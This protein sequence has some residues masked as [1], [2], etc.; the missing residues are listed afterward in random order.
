MYDQYAGCFAGL[1]DATFVCPD[2][3]YWD[4][5]RNHCSPIPLPPP[6]VPP[7]V[8]PAVSGWYVGEGG[9][10]QPD[11]YGVEAQRKGCVPGQYWDG[12]YQKCLPIGGH[13]IAPVR[14][15]QGGDPL[16]PICPDNT[17]WSDASQRC[18]PLGASLTGPSCSPGM[19]WDD[20]LKKCLPRS[21]GLA[22]MPSTLAD[23]HMQHATGYWT[24][25]GDMDIYAVGAAATTD[26]VVHADNA[27]AQA[28]SA[29]AA[30]S[31]PAATGTPAGQAAQ[32]ATAHAN[33]ALVHAQTA[34]QKAP[35]QPHEAI[36]HSAEAKKHAHAAAHHAREAHASLHR[37][38]AERFGHERFGRERFGR[39]RE[40]GRRGFERGRFGREWWRR[41]EFV[42]YERRYGRGW[43][44]RPE[45]AEYARLYGGVEEVVVPEY[46]APRVVEEY[47]LPADGDYDD[48]VD[49]GD[50]DAG[51]DD[52]DVD[53]G[54]DAAVQG[55]YTGW[56]DPFTT[57]YPGY[58]NPNMAA[59]WDSSFE[60]PFLTPY[61]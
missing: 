27:T 33:Q 57:P 47:V 3:Q 20:T 2:G 9:E 15:G 26:A 59:A 46:A 34:A 32:A 49:A 22:P 39:G 48:D 45:F 53:A 24:G 19:Y 16:H 25:A 44:R 54:D 5:T 50:D 29:Q 21:G 60:Y 13:A 31:H 30:A 37:G 43:W 61:W 1:G 28:Q 12:W 11:L 40:F 14:T 6:T 35:T 18:V 55:M 4:S 58:F 17:M 56:Q 23:W 10:I 52:A 38:H 41:P 8:P 36:A 42:E 51:D 7:M